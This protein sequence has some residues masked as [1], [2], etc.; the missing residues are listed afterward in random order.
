MTM[1]TRLGGAFH[2]GLGDHLSLQHP[3]LPRQ[4]HGVVGRH[5]A[6]AQNPRCGTEGEAGGI[7]HRADPRGGLWIRL[8]SLG[9]RGDLSISISI[10]WREKMRK[11]SCSGVSVVPRLC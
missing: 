11:F 10:K 8:G 4:R 3:A 9:K 6:G 7:G 5:R 2:R 1:E